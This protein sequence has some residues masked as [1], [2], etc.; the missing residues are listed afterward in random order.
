MPKHEFLSP[1]AISNRMKAKGLQK[2]RWY[3]QL[4]NKQC[5]DENGFKCHQTS[6]GHRRMMLV[7]GE[8]PEKF[9]EGFS[10]IFQNNFL[11]QMKISHP[12][13][14]IMA[15]EFYQN[16]IKDKH[17]I[18]MNSTKWITLTDFVRHLGRS[19]KC[20]VEESEKGWY[21]T[22]NQS[23]SAQSKLDSEY[24]SSHL[25][26]KKLREIAAQTSYLNDLK[27]TRVLHDL[28]KTVH[29]KL[30]DCSYPPISFKLKPLDRNLSLGDTL[31]K[32]NNVREE[33]SFV[34]KE[35]L[36]EMKKISFNDVKLKSSQ[37]SYEINREEPWLAKNIIVNVISKE[38]KSNGLYGKKGIVLEIIN[39]YVAELQILDNGALLRVDQNEFETVIPNIGH[40]VLILKGTYRGKTAI[41]KE[42]SISRFRARLHIMDTIDE[43]IEYECFSK[44]IQ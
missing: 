24:D 31:E 40:T 23:N 28:S 8:N 15:N 35:K 44:L 2:L 27:K 33:R 37:T 1:K 21:I 9:I 5:R 41:I 6:E 29:G 18:H 10:E 3:C 20:L 36:H 11:E 34:N 32:N 7:F 14:R 26:R 42:I 25:E 22:L 30:E 43:W 38:L 12:Y 13:S 39:E 17:H 16:Y 19:G 4:C